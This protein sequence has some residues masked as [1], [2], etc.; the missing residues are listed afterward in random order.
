MEKEI[1]FSKK[2][3]II[4]LAAAVLVSIIVGYSSYINKQKDH[5]VN[6]LITEGRSLI[7]DGHYQEANEK[8]KEAVNIKATQDAKTLLL[9]TDS[10]VESEN[11]FANGIKAFQDKNYKAAS[12]AFSM[13][14]DVDSKNYETARNYI[15]QSFDLLA[16]QTLSEAKAFYSKG[17]YKEAYQALKEALALSP[18]LEEA[19]KLETTYEQ[20]QKRQEEQEQ[21]EIAQRARAAA[22]ESMKQYEVGTGAVGIAVGDVKRTSR[23]NGDFGYYNYVTDPK[24]DQFL[25]LWIG[26][27]NYGSGTCHV[28]PNDFSVTSPDGYTANYDT[29]SFNTKY[30]DATDVPPRSY[31]A[32]WLIFIVPKAEKYVLHYDG[33][34]GSVNKDIIP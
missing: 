23:V 18:S 20:A 4:L 10:L 19:K 29:S 11:S 16:A 25:W 9:L 7:A 21:K 2:N 26:A 13:V 6:N 15:K 12:D 24:N 27:K 17:A 14:K 34:G 30:L 32:G 3:K 1:W 28:N 22:R 8:A 33:W 31:V 5:A